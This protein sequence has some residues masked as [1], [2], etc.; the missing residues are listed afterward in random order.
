MVF[1]DVNF[2]SL[3]GLDTAGA[4]PQ[5]QGTHPMLSLPQ[6]PVPHYPGPSIDG[7]TAQ[8]GRNPEFFAPHQLGPA[9]EPQPP[10]RAVQNAP[11]HPETSMARIRCD[12]QLQDGYS[13]TLDG[14]TFP[15]P[16]TGPGGIS[17]DED[18]SGSGGNYF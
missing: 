12:W 6:A 8:A 5:T 3:Q 14:S 10:H 16:E 17:P 18:L 9:E 13:Y 1:P 4:A 15:L 7:W 2:V 11:Q